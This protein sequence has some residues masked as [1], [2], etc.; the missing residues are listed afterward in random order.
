MKTSKNKW[1]LIHLPSISNFCVGYITGICKVTT[2]KKQLQ[3][4][5]EKTCAAS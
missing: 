3:Y 4:K 1:K 2:S 5:L